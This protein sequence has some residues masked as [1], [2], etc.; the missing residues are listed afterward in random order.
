MFEDW[1]KELFWIFIGGAFTAIVGII[2][3]VINWLSQKHKTYSDNAW[4]DYELRRDVYLDL[5]A[6]IDC[7]FANAP[8]TDTSAKRAWHKTARKVRIVGS[9]EVVLAL[10]ALTSAI[11]TSSGDAE[12]RLY[13]LNLALRR[14]IR[15]IRLRPPEGTKLEAT[16]FPIES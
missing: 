3:A 14:D 7:L 11:K 15:T 4:A 13:D 6:G 9:D 12:L 1:P 2:G 8:D 16:A 5:V 10:N